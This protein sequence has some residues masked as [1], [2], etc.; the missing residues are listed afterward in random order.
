MAAEQS[1]KLT[2]QFDLWANPYAERYNACRFKEEMCGSY[3]E[4]ENDTPSL[5]YGRKVLGLARAI[6]NLQF[7]TTSDELRGANV[8]NMMPLVQEAIAEL[9]GQDSNLSEH[10]TT[11]EA[12]GI[13]VDVVEDVVGGLNRDNLRLLPQK[14]FIPFVN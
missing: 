13:L 14:G 1:W 9:S 12:M 8:V 7:R 6:N 10:P 11:Q 3:S 4:N 5:A 2:K